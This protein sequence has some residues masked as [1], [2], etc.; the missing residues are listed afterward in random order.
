MGLWTKFFS[1]NQTENNPIRNIPNKLAMRVP[2]GKEGK[3]GKIELDIKNLNTPPIP[4]P[5]NTNKYKSNSLC[6]TTS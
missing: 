6:T 1:T 2:I 3:K 4:L 5:K